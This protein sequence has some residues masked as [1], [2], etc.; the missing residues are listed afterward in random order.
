MFV[1]SHISYYLLNL[2]LLSGFLHQ[3]IY[4]F[5]KHGGIE[6]FFGVQF[7]VVVLLSSL[8]Q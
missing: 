5:F 4:S 8:E 3:S 6:V 7:S 2:L 1:F